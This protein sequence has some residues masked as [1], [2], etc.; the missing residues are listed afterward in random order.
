MHFAL[1]S[2]LTSEEAN[3]FTTRISVNFSNL[4]TTLTNALPLILDE[5]ELLHIIQAASDY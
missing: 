1:L 5:F 2:G 4:Q 3:I